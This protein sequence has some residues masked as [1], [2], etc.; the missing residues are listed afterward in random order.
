MSQENAC[1]SHSLFAG[2][3]PIAFD[4]WD[5]VDQAEAYDE[6]KAYR[7]SAFLALPADPGAGNREPGAG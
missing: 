7:P 4:F 2:H 5:Q 6:I 3:P 1:R